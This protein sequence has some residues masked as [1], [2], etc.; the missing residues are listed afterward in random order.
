[1]VGL[2]EIVYEKLERRIRKVLAALAG[3][4]AQ[5]RKCRVADEFDAFLRTRT[6]N[7]RGWQTATDV[8]VFVWLYWLDS[9][10]NG[11][12]W[13]HDETC[14]G[15]GLDDSLQCMRDGR[16]GKRYAAASLDKGEF[17]KLK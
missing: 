14:L 1:M 8:D 16:C 3:K 15:L 17:S 2:F 5:Q 6:N 4:A 13:V 10:G 12:K 11:T 7:G 9:H